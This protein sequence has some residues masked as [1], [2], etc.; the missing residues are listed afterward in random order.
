MEWYPVKNYE[1][2]YIFCLD[3]VTGIK[4]KI[5][6]QTIIDKN[7]VVYQRPGKDVI[8]YINKDGYYSF[9]ANRNCKS[10][11]YKVHRAIAYQFIPEILGKT[12]VNHINGIKTDNRIENLEWCTHEENTSHAWANGMV[13]KLITIS[14]ETIDEIRSKYPVEQGKTKNYIDIGKEYGINRHTVSHILNRKN[15][16]R[17]K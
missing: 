16:L 11:V 14:Q 6:P 8:P 4:V 5:L 9:A 7:G 17:Y 1:D 12:H 3:E 13:K 15:Y 10:I 2:K